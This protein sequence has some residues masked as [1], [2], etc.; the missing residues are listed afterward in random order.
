VQH[1]TRVRTLFISLPS[2]PAQVLG[3]L[4]HVMHS[5]YHVRFAKLHN[6]LKDKCKA[7]LGKPYFDNLGKLAI[8]YAH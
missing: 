1:K 4:D 8:N 2:S 6:A 5:K 3:L 7:S